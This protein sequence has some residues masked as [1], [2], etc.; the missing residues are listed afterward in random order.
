[1][2]R[3]RR[4]GVTDTIRESDTA[5]IQLSVGGRVRCITGRLKGVEGVVEATRT[6]GRLLVRISKGVSLE[7][8]GICFQRLDFPSE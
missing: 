8:P 5:A 4:E 2:A 7:L 6:G 1:M 3:N